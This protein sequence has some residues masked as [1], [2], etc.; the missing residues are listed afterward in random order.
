MFT[1]ALLADEHAAH[2]QR[3]WAAMASRSR[4]ARIAA[5]VEQCA[6]VPQSLVGRLTSSLR[7][8][9]EPCTTS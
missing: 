5:H 3:E 1:D 6:V 7:P 8:A 9:P 2:V 4:L